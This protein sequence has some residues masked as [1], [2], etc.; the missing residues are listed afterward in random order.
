MVTLV[1][2]DVHQRT[3]NVASV[4]SSEK[5][6][7]VVFLG[8]WFDSFYEPP[9]VTSFRDT[10]VFLRYLM[11][12]HSEKEKFVFLLG[13]HDTQYIYQNKASSSTKIV[14]HR[15]YYCSGFA[16]AKAKKFRREFFDKNLK[17]SF[18]WEKI[19]IAHKSQGFI[20][21]HAGIMM[22]HLKYGESVDSLITEVLP[23]VWRNFRNELHSRNYLISDVG[24]C[25]CGNASI[26]GILWLDANNEFYPSPDIGKQ[27][28]GHTTFREPQVYAKDTEYESWCLDTVQH[29]GVITDGKLEIRQYNKY[30]EEEKTQERDQETEGVFQKTTGV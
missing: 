16:K 19:K 26:G 2:P 13:N 23:D 12:E 29:Y 9:Y 11:R 20:F 27:I 24:A 10:C 5:Y 18:F 25:R 3:N 30:R 8:D 22:N 15:L 4:L 28:F 7:E 6:D 14:A 17:D 21:S 1:I